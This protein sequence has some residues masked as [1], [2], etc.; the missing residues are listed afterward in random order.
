MAH[1]QPAA[2]Q[3]AAPGSGGGSG[4]GSLALTVALVMVALLLVTLTTALVIWTVDRTDGSDP[5]TDVRTGSRDVRGSNGQVRRD[6]SAR[7]DGDA[8]RPETSMREIPTTT[9]T[10]VRPRI[11][12]V[13]GVTASN[14][15]PSVDLLCAP[16]THATYGPELLFDGDD[17]TGWGAS[18]A[19]GTGEWVD[20]RF[21]GPVELTRIGMTSGFNRVAPRK[22][23]GCVEV[24]A[25]GFNR[26]VTV[27]EFTFDDGSSVMHQL[28]EIPELQF[29]DLDPPPRTSTVRI[30]IRGTVRPPGADNDTIISE[31]IF[32]GR[33]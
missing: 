11:L 12:E 16:Y 24:H 6:D 22:D 17:N 8:A 2:Q 5:E 15:R 31:A 19:D 9:T 29:I 10:V 33:T 18:K 20:V 1:Q 28:D 32:E 27:A 25:F 4:K 7:S 13:A 23:R 14:V 3:L 26:H 21:D 30:T